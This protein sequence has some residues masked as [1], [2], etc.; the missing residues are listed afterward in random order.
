[1]L[2]IFIACQHTAADARYWYSNSVCLSVCP[3]VCPWHA[4]IVWKRLNISS[5]FLIPKGNRYRRNTQIRPGTHFRT[6]AALAPKWI[7]R[8]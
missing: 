4:G 2:L 7:P 5:W 6:R 8:S 3:S 1:M